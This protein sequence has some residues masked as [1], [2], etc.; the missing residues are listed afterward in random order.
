MEKVFDKAYFVENVFETLGNTMVR[1]C[2]SIYEYMYD[3]DIDFNHAMFSIWE[4]IGKNYPYKVMLLQAGRKDFIT[5]DREVIAAV[6]TLYIYDNE[7]K[8]D[9]EDTDK[10]YPEFGILKYIKKILAGANVES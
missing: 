1:D 8:K 5:S 6:I 9:I 10:L 3:N 2:A 4:Y 7:T